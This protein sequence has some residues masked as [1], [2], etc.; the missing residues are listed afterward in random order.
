MKSQDLG[1]ITIAFGITWILYLAITG[2]LPAERMFISRA[3]FSLFIGFAVA[4]IIRI[5]WEL[6]TDQ[7]YWQQ[8]KKAMELI[9]ADDKQ[10]TK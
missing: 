7:P 2:V 3:L 9:R 6:H 1:L 5:V 8:L 4:T 10:H